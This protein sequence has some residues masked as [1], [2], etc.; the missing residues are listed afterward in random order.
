MPRGKLR[1]E[2]ADAGALLAAI[3]NGTWEARDVLGAPAKTPDLAVHA[4][5]GTTVIIEVTS[6]VNERRRSRDQAAYK[7]SWTDPRLSRDWVVV[8]QDEPSPHFAQRIPGVAGHL[9]IMEAFDVHY[10]GINWLHGRW[11]ADPEFPLPPPGSELDVARR[12]ALRDMHVD[13][14]FVVSGGGGR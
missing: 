7:R 10:V 1:S 2:E 5:D 4:A 9:A 8:F 6:V 3:L 12:G 13:S 11:P 14:T